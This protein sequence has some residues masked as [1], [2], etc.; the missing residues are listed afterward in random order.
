M[1]YDELLRDHRAT[2]RDIFASWISLGLFFMAMIA[3]SHL[4]R[5]CE[6]L[7]NLA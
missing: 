7:S 6:H 1:K 4:S 5:V 3:G 2:R